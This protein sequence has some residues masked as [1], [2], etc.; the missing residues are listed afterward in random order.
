MK[1]KSWKVA[2][3]MHDMGRYGDIYDVDVEGHEM[4]HD[5]REYEDENGY[6]TVTNVLEVAKETEKALYLNIGGIQT[7]LPQSPL[8]QRQDPSGGGYTTAGRKNMSDTTR[9][10]IELSNLNET[11]RGVVY[12]MLRERGANERIVHDL[13]V[14][15]DFARRLK[16]KGA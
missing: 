8:A 11:E 14:L 10:I 15:A 13:D 16:V 3:I 6:V 5:F 1:I 7:W 4:F 9:G 2:Q 12:D